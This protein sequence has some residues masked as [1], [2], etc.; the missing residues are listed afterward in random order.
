M[1]QS[2]KRFEQQSACCAVGDLAAGQHEGERLASV[3]SG[4]ADTKATCFLIEANVTLDPD[5]CLRK[6]ENGDKLGLMN[7]L[8]LLTAST[9]PRVRALSQRQG[10]AARKNFSCWIA[11]N[12]LISHDSDERIQG[13]QTKSK[14]N[15]SPSAAVFERNSRAPRES[16]SSGRTN[17]AAPRPQRTPNRFQPETGRPRCL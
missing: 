12:P 10:K 11:R 7:I 9:A 6:R 5:N 1:P 13:I 15:P 3:H 17:V 4:T 14:G 2:G 16:K 8:A